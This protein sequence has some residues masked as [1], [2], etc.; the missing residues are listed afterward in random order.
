MIKVYRLYEPS[1]NELRF[2][3]EPVPEPIAK[4]TVIR[5]RA[6]SLLGKLDKVGY[7]YV[8]QRAGQVSVRQDDQVDEVT[9]RQWTPVSIRRVVA[10]VERSKISSRACVFEA[11]RH[12]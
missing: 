6:A 4:Q 2:V 9:P 12:Q 1:L 11:Q 10:Y 7:Q 3:A 8:A 5:I